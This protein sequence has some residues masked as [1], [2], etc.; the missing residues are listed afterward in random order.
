MLL[1]WV[2]GETNHQILCINL[3]AKYLAS[4]YL[5]ILAPPPIQYS[6][7]SSMGSMYK[8]G[9]GGVYTL[10]GNHDMVNCS[11]WVV[12]VPVMIV[13][14]RPSLNTTC[15]RGRPMTEVHSVT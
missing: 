1:L 15:V 14:C 13:V 9:G 8:G 10:L 6:H 4:I 2:K 5:F 12:V 3:E 11:L 7:L